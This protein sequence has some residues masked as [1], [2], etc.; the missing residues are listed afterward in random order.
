MVAQWRRSLL[1]TQPAPSV[2]NIALLPVDVVDRP[3]KD[4]PHH[5]LPQ[6]PH[7]S[8]SPA[9]PPGCEIEIEVG[10]RR[11]RI[12]GVSHEFAE[13]D[14]SQGAGADHEHRSR[15]GHLLA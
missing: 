14:R 8:A 4:I 2:P 11:I 15:R 6:T 1:D 7:V 12:R 5:A 13:R 3:A 10:K 9:M